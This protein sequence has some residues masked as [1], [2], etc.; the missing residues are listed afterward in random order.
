[1]RSVPVE[2]RVWSK[3]EKQQSGCWI[4]TAMRLPN[5]YGYIRL[6][7]GTGYAHRVMYELLK[8]PIPKGMTI[9]HLCNNR[10]C[11][12]PDHMEI[13]TQ[14]EN[15]LRSLSAPPAI[16]ARKTHCLRGHELSEEN[17]YRYRGRRLCRSCIRLR[18]SRRRRA[19]A[20]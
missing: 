16:N 11:V 10:A 12:N 5:G 6:N 14:R 3:I 19:K 7:G 15:V 1:M 20:S 8:G 4:W 2:K 17:L 18:E 9:D 13:K